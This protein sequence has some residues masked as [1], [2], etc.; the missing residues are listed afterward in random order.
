VAVGEPGEL[1]RIIADLGPAAA[2]AERIDVLPSGLDR[3]GRPAAVAGP[4]AGPWLARHLTRSK[5]G[6]ALGAGGAKGYAHLAVLSALEQ[7]GYTI[8][9]VGGSSVGAVVA[10]CV[11][12]GQPPRAIR[13]WLDELFNEET[14]KQ[15]FTPNLSGASAGTDVIRAILGRLGADCTFAQLNIPLTVMCADLDNR[16]P[17][18]ITGWP[19]T[20]ALVAAT[21]VPGL[22]PPYEEGDRRLVDGVVLVPVPVDAVR[23]AGADLV[24]GVNLMSRQTLQAWPGTEPSARPARRQRSLETLLEVMDLMQLDASTSHAARADVVIAP[25]FGPCTWRD[26]WL[27]ERFLD[28]GALAARSA[29]EQLGQL[30]SPIIN[31]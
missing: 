5:L 27:A 22:F 18:P 9:A 17:A 20:E 21:S 28:A 26:F 4:G 19:V 16:I 10:A 29:I 2:R 3:N 11:A 25:K 13:E 14:S 24:V 7:A 23:E 15:V 1:D 31:S 12:M 6:V 30:A 8:D